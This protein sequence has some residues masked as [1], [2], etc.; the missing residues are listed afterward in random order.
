MHT[1]ALGHRVQSVHEACAHTLHTLHTVREGG[2]GPT[3]DLRRPGTSSATRRDRNARSPMRA[4]CKRPPRGAETGKRPDG[5]ARFVDVREGSG[6]AG[7]QNLFAALFSQ[8]FA[9]AF[10]AAFKARPSGPRSPV[11]AAAILRRSRRS[12]SPAAADPRSTLI[13]RAAELP[14]RPLAPWPALG[15][16]IG[17]FAFRRADHDSRPRDSHLPHCLFL[18]RFRV[19]KREVATHGHSR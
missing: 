9:A 11:F 2:R 4:F 18:A 19:A 1:R 6:F 5:S 14:R 16:G 12:S 15:A 10:V 13:D 7:T 17:A 3:V 8:V